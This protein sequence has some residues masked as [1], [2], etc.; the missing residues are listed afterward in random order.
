MLLLSPFSVLTCSRLSF[1]SCG[2]QSV[3][4]S[5]WGLDW[6]CRL[7]SHPHHAL[8]VG[9]VMVGPQMVLGKVMGQLEEKEEEEEKGTQA[10]EMQS[11]LVMATEE[12]PLLEEQVVLEEVVEED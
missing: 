12:H 4:A 11:D 1:Q 3:M 8:L 10:G 7:C 6:G 2:V 5:H 9:A